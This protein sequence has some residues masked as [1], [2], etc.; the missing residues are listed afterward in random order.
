VAVKFCTLV[1]GRY[2]RRSLVWSLAVYA[3]DFLGF[4]LSLQKNAEIAHQ[5]VSG[6][7]LPNT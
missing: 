6:R 7:L 2:H 5:L 3:G 1:F 4:Y